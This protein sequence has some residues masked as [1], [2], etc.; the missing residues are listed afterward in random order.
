MLLD[1]S[2]KVGINFWITSGIITTLGLMVG[3]L[4]GTHSKLAVI[5][6]V[7]TIAIADA[8]SDSLGIHI[9]QEWSGKTQ[10]EVRKATI[11]TF[12]A[13]FLFALTFMVP[14]LLIPNLF[15][16]V[17]VSA[18]WWLLALGYLSYTIA[19]SSREEPIKV[20]REHIMIAILVIIVTYST[21]I[22]IDKI[23]VVS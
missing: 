17:V 4:S 6:G 5:G 21:G 11:A 18:I 7:L 19:K 23:F 3:L 14:V 22:L 9:S 20:I 10:K 8:M 13:K 2:I 16:A 15:S 1:K 12:L